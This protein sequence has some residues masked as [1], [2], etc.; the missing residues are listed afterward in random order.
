MNSGART[1]QVCLLLGSNLSPERNLPRATSLLRRYV[2]VAHASLVWETP[3]VGSPGP[4]FLN[5]AL[6]VRTPL[7]AEQLKDRVLSRIEA[8]LGRRRTDDKYASRPIDIDIVAWNC[9]VTDADIWRFAHIAVPVSEV[10]PCDIRSDQGETLA[11]VAKRLMQTTPIRLRGE[12]SP[13]SLHYGE[14]SAQNPRLAG[15]DVD[16]QAKARSNI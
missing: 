3:A 9:T 1:N 6:L 13:A 12:L 5:A 10:L 14:L 8:H 7:E 11:Q 2:E 15:S 16:C 4:N